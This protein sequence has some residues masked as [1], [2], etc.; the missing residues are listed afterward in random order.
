MLLDKHEKRYKDFLRL[1]AADKKN[2][3]AQRSLGYVELEKPIPRGWDVV[4]VPRADIQN[5]E[6]ANSFWEVINV[7]ARKGFIRNKTYLKS[8]K[9]AYQSWPYRPDW[10]K[11]SQ[12][13]YDKLT[14]AVKKHFNPATGLHYTDG[15]DR[16]GK[17]Y[18][19][20]NTPN[21][22]W[23]L[24][25][26]RSY[27]TRVKVIDTDLL[28]E[29]AEIDSQL[30]NYRYQYHFDEWYGSSVPKS[31][32]KP[33]N[34]SYRRSCKQITKLLGEGIEKEIPPLKEMHGRAKWDYW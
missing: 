25:L 9:L 17:K 5:R 31:F 19:Q 30:N 7:C 21:F 16:W 29:E 23:E 22:Y 18:Y 13:T 12:D 8:K 27:I 1:K 3:E 14:P 6:D 15:V 10:G 33:Y 24:K 20:Q 26:V 11:I 32:M 28:K 2:W 34:R 4:F